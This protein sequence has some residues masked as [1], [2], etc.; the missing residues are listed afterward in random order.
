MELT[1]VAELI[2]GQSDLDKR[3]AAVTVF[4]RRHRTMLI[5]GMVLML[6]A[7]LFG[8][9][10]KILSKENI[11]IAGE[12]TP[13]LMVVNLLLLCIG[14]GLIC[15]PFLLM[16]TNSPRAGKPV[17]NRTEG[18]LKLDPQLLSDEPASVTEQTTEFLQS[19]EAG[20]TAR[21]AAPQKD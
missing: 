16:M 6:A 7:V 19:S 10:L 20:V 1:K 9:S 8:S 5:L 3:D 18:T 13:Y 4:Q 17:S 2:R 12:F 11:Q 15:F 21:T 14:I